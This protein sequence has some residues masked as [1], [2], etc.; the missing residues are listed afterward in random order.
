LIGR[1]IGIASWRYYLINNDKLRTWED[2]R[3]YAN[4]ES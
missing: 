1:P 4:G 2:N 3:G